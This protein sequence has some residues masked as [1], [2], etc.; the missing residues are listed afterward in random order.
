MCSSDLLE[1]A[2]V[3]FLWA[4]REPPKAEFA[5]PDDYTNLEKVLPNGF[6]ERTAGIGLV[7]G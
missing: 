1:Q 5:L 3:R 4:L 2:G 6:L 7:C